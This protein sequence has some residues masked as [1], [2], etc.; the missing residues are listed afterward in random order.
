MDKLLEL[1]QKMASI[2]KQDSTTASKKQKQL[3]LKLNEL[4]ANLDDYEKNRKLL[5]DL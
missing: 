3:M 2:L 5:K 1:A 4:N